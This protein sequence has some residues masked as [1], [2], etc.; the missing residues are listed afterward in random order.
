[1]KSVHVCFEGSCRRDLASTGRRS[2]VLA[3]TQNQQKVN[4][5]FL[6]GLQIHVASEI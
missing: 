6:S 5:R 1:M 3:L 2:C 4:L